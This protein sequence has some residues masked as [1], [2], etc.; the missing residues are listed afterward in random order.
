MKFRWAAVNSV[1][2]HVVLRLSRL[3]V[4]REGLENSNGQYHRVIREQSQRN[5]LRVF[6]KLY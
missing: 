6:F 3:T 4:C 1:A 5:F 2:E